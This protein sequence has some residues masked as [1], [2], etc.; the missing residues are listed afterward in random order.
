MM[1][2]PAQPAPRAAAKV[3]V[4]SG[5][6]VAAAAALAMAVASLKVDEGKRN[7]DYLDIARVP[8][9]VTT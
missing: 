9:A 7:V 4:A 8:T 3:G 5:L 2:A 1:A 6:G